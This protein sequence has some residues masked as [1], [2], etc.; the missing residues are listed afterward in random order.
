MYTLQEITIKTV[1]GSPPITSKP[2]SSWW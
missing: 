2:F 1:S